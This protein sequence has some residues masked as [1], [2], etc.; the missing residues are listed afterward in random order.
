[1]DFFGRRDYMY[2]MYSC[3]YFTVLDNNVTIKKRNKNSNKAENTYYS[4]ASLE[5]TMMIRSTDHCDLSFSS[6]PSSSL[7][8]YF[9]ENRS[10]QPLL[11]V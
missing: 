6:V 11:P 4:L 2:F 9:L 3:M 10:D 1:M 8:G 7:L 5:Q